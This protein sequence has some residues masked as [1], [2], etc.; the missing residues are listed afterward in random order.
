MALEDW[1]QQ[2]ID[3]RGDIP[4]L[5]RETWH[6]VLARVLFDEGPM[7]TDDT[8]EA[9]AALA[10]VGKHR[11]YFAFI[12]VGR[13][14]ADLSQVI[15]TR[16]SAAAA[17]SSGTPSTAAPVHPDLEDMFG[18]SLDG[19]LRLPDT[20]RLHAHAQAALLRGI[21]RIAEAATEAETLGAL[22]DAYLTLPSP[23]EDDFQSNGG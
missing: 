13:A 6:A 7:T 5:E 16:E 1:Q 15:A 3:S 22:A 23:D 18:G 14:Q 2:F 19:L 10:E 11:D 8:V 20:R 12:R 21:E 17:E 4:G 9:L